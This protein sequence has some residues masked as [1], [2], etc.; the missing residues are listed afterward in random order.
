MPVAAPVIKKTI[1]WK[2]S[3][4][5]VTFSFESAPNSKIK[6]ALN[7]ILLVALSLSLHTGRDA[8]TTCGE[9]P[10]TARLPMLRSSITSQ[11]AMSAAA[12]A[13]NP[14]FSENL[15]SPLFSFLDSQNIYTWSPI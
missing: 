9:T 8:Y 3:V 5:G 15:R 14:E 6:T 12:Q 7:S 1:G 2:F 11:L 4:Y 13:G 10:P